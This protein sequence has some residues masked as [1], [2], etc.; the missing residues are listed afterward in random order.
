MDR[1]AVCL[2]LLCFAHE[3]AASG[4]TTARSQPGLGAFCPL[5]RRYVDEVAAA[6]K[7]STKVLTM[8]FKESACD[9]SMRSFLEMYGIVP[10][11]PRPVIVSR[12]VRRWASRQDWRRESVQTFTPS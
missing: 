12:R 4:S 11:I 6:T 2:Y 7:G 9:A 8:I 3:I 5:V 1:E 10:Y